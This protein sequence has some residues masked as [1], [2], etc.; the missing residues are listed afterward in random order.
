MTIDLGGILSAVLVFI[1][2][3]VITVFTFARLYE[4]Q[5][6]TRARVQEIVKDQ[7]SFDARLGNAEQE[8]S[9]FN[10][11]MGVQDKRHEELLSQFK[12]VHDELRLLRG[13]NNGD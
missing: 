2:N 10:M 5:E 11:Y 6:N 4:R 7:N 9:A 13:N 12:A 1:I 8:I 3:L